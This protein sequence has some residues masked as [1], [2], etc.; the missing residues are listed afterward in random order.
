M[1]HVLLGIVIMS[2]NQITAVDNAYLLKMCNASSSCQISLSQRGYDCRKK[3]PG[4][5][6]R[7]AGYCLIR[8]L[9]ESVIASKKIFFFPFQWHVLKTDASWQWKNSTN[10]KRKLIS[11]MSFLGHMSWAVLMKP[12]AWQWPILHGILGC[13]VALNPWLEVDLLWIKYR[14]D[15]FG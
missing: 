8:F 2:W 5:A 6:T 14:F 4:I 12:S 15:L 9:Q 1:E 7:W 3:L 11:T 10:T 13:F